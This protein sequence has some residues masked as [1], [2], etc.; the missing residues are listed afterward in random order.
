MGQRQILYAV[1]YDITNSVLGPIQR[2]R[3]SGMRRRIAVDS[4]LLPARL[5]MP[6]TFVYRLFGALGIPR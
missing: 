2:P 5:G 3:V 1:W 4:A 6:W